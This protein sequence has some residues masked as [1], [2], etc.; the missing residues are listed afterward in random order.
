MVTPAKRLMH[1]G[2]LLK[3]AQKYGKRLQCIKG[4]VLF[5]MGDTADSIYYVQ[6]GTVKLSVV[7]AQG[8]EAVFALLGPGD[9]FGEG[10]IAGQS[11]RLMTAT[12]LSAGSVMKIMK[13]KIVRLLHRDNVLA[14]AL[15]TY[16][17]T[18]QR[19]VQED[20]ID[21]L[22]NSAER[23]LARALLLLANYGTAGKT[24]GTIPMVSQTLL[25]EMI[26]ASR[27]RVS[28][29][30]NKFRKLGFIEYDHGLTIHSSLLSVVLHD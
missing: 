18:R 26:G 17:I 21:Q 2:F 29:L 5:T 4:Q 19:K 8:K 11:V 28:L 7:S 27:P 1:I 13:P 14:G 24:E 23:R 9:F 25:A 12:A 10:C 22:F 20:L 6:N 3:L 30:M 15:I 16:L